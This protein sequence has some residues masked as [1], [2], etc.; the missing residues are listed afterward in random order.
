MAPPSPRK[1]SV[2]VRNDSTKQSAAA[3]SNQMLMADRDTGKRFKKQQHVSG[4]DSVA[5]TMRRRA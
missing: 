1:W 4:T 5:A 3:A 2:A